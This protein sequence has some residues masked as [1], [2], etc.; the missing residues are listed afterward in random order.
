[1]SEDLHRIPNIGSVQYTTEPAL[2][3]SSSQDRTR[4]ILVGQ[5]AN[6]QGQDQKIESAILLG[7][8][9]E[10]T[11]SRNFINWGVWLDTKF[12]HAMLIVGKRGS[13]KSYDLGVIAEGLCA[14]ED[15]FIAKGTEKFSM[16]LFDTQSQFWTLAMPKESVDAGQQAL[17]KKWDIIN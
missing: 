11:S 16:V 9:C 4:S 10:R 5:V 8:V 14:A 7:S 17:I 15:S 3:P 6:P 13:G 2:Q 1:M 12:P